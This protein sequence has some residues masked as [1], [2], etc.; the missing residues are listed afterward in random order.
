MKLRHNSRL[1][2]L[3]YKISDIEEKNKINTCTPSLSAF[4]TITSQLSISLAILIMAEGFY[5]EVTELITKL[6]KHIC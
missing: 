5:N 6:T 1:Y 2:T 4:T 3:I